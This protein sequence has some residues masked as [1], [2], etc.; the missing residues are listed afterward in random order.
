MGR[1]PNFFLKHLVKYEG[2]VNP[3]SNVIWEIEYRLFFINSFA[4]ASLNSFKSVLGENP[5]RSTVVLYNWDLLMAIA[6]QKSVTLNSGSCQFFSSLR[7]NNC[8]R[9]SSLGLVATRLFPW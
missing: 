7:N 9:F 1:R 2:L 3:E 6:W 5:A 4:F 8:N